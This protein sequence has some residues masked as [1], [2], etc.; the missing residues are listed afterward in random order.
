MRSIREDED[1]N[2]GDRLAGNVLKNAKITR[3]MPISAAAPIE[4]IPVY[5][6]GD[7]PDLLALF[8]GLYQE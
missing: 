8:A 6:R 7:R 2:R 4:R 1:G 5:I 3:K